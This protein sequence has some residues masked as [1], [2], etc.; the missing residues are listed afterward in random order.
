MEIKINQTNADG[1]RHGH[2]EQYY[3]HNKALWYKC[4]YDN[5]SIIGYD[6]CYKDDG[7]LRYQCYF[8]NGGEIGC[9]QYNKHQFFYNNP[10]KKFG[11]H[12][13]WK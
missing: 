4:N 9:E 1:L 2:W 12:I 7:D 10:G 11:E 8:K 13:I 5:S 6:I 3:D